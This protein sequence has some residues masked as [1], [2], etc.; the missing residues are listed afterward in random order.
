MTTIIDSNLSIFEINIRVSHI[1]IEDGSTIEIR[2]YELQVKN[3]C[4]IYELISIM[5]SQK[6]INVSRYRVMLV[7][8]GKHLYDFKVNDKLSGHGIKQD[9]VI[10]MMMKCIITGEI[11]NSVLYNRKRS[12][13]DNLFKDVKPDT[14]FKDHKSNVKNDECKD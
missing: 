14:R 2:L 13:N 12:V 6:D 4:T 11:S 8:Y 9:S 7:Y 5:L 1:E 10:T 3:T